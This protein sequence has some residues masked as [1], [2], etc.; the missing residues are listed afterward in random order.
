MFCDFA[1]EVGA[2]SSQSFGALHNYTGPR[3]PVERGKEA[4]T[5]A[6]EV[7]REMIL[8]Y[9]R[10][11]GGV[12]KNVDLVRHFRKYLQLS[13][14]RAKGVYT[15]RQFVYAHQTRLSGPP[16][17]NTRSSER[18]FSFGTNFKASLLAGGR[19][20]E[21]TLRGPRGRRLLCSNQHL[22]PPAGSVPAAL[23]VLGHT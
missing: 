8:D 11:K 20:C 13:N 1:A 2:Q 18:Q 17:N 3:I 12:V 14:Q 15:R 16:K 23:S 6:A 10:S 5:M 7:T 21:H 4:K 9:M 22:I 19:L